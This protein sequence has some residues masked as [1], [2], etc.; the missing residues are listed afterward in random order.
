MAVAAVEK[1][2][3]WQRE[4]EAGYAEEGR[5]EAENNSV[6]HMNFG[7]EYHDLSWQEAIDKELASVM[8]G[9]LLKGGLLERLILCKQQ[10]NWF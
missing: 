3:E 2:Q 5:V 10:M 4:V 1:E 8:E 7:S 9:T 6:S